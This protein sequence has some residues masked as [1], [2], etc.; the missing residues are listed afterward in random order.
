[1]RLLP[2][3]RLRLIARPQVGWHSLGKYLESWL[4]RPPS[5]GFVSTSTTSL[6]HSAASRAAVMPLMPP[7]TTN[8]V[9]F[10]ATTSVIDIPPPRNCSEKTP[11]DY[12][13]GNNTPQ[14]NR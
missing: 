10:V 9:S 8:I 11:P 1:M 12:R 6:P 4:T 3:R 5:D 14:S 13:D 7:P 2:L